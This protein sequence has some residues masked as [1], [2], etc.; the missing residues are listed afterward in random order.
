MPSKSSF[1][2]AGLRTLVL[3][4]VVTALMVAPAAAQTPSVD[5]YTANGPA[6]EQRLG[7]DAKSRTGGDP[8]GDPQSAVRGTD[9][10]QA[11]ALPF[12]G[13]DL[14]LLGGAGLALLGL[15]LGLRVLVR[16]V[17]QVG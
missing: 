10:R 15:G 11:S 2:R 8:S 9:R 6:L 1:S 4:C 5:G 7:P 17:G 3:T 14:V 13:M 12:T 16:P